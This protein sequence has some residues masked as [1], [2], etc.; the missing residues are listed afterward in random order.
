[1]V[2]EGDG[3]LMSKRV[4]TG[5]RDCKSCTNSSVAHAGRGAG[6]F[7]AGMA[8]AGLSEVGI[9]AKK[10]C[11]VCGH[12][13]SLHEAERQAP[14]AAPPAPKPTFADVKQQWQALRGSSAVQPTTQTAVTAS[15][16]T[17]GAPQNDAT[18]TAPQA[19][20]PPPGWYTDQQ[21][22]SMVRWYDGA[23]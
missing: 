10:K 15:Q 18:P 6:R 19:S 5:C 2:A 1:M 7:M 4:M 11:R 14:A 8:T 22:V 13:M 17:Q 20:G 16:P 21:D 12:Q 9:A 23:G 3:I